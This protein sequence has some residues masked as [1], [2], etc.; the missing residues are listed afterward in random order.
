MCLFVDPGHGEKGVV[1]V[2]VSGD[3]WQRGVGGPPGAPN[4]PIWPLSCLPLSHPT[5]MDISAVF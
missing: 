4:P 5:Q 3:L 1:Y 2:L